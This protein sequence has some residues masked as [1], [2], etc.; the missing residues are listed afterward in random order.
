MS[1]ENIALIESFYAAMGR[2]D[3]AAVFGLLD[4]NI[5]WNE[6]E[7]FIYAD[8][9]PYVGPNALLNGLFMRLIGEWEGFKA[10]PEKF[11]G[12]GD[13]VAMLGRYHGTYR[14]TGKTVNAQVVHVFTMKDGKVIRFQQ[15]TDTAQF[16]DAVTN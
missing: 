6:A 11:I 9:S 16:R 8:Q 12:T 5:E 1:Q 14:E 10:V 15:Y 2:G 7:N 4:E 13:T 3:V